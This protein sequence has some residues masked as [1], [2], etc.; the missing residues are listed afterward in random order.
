MSSHPKVVQVPGPGFE[1]SQSVAMAMP[2]L[3]QPGDARVQMEERGEDGRDPAFY[4]PDGSCNFFEFG[5]ARGCQ[6]GAGRWMGFSSGS[7]HHLSE[8]PSLKSYRLPSSNKFN[9]PKSPPCTHAERGLDSQTV[10]RVY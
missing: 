5:P 4:H 1:T 7:L 2:R 3:P 8:R 10:N 9:F 6:K